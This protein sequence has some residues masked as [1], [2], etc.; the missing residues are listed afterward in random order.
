MQPQILVCTCSANQQCRKLPGCP[1]T[2]NAGCPQWTFQDHISLWF[3]K[4]DE[5]DS[6][7]SEREEI[8]TARNTE[9][10]ARIYHYYLDTY[11]FFHRIPGHPLQ[12]LLEAPLQEKFFCGL[13]TK[14]IVAQ[15][16]IKR[17]IHR[18]RYIWWLTLMH[19]R[20]LPLEEYCLSAG[21]AGAML[22]HR[23]TH[24][25]RHRLRAYGPRA[26]WF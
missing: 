18:L 14:L 23:A 9:A 12:G 3:L 6:R 21:T 11:A 24:D 7:I 2:N 10:I 13:Y 4:R 16:H 5:P 15:A 17:T 8:N 19:S 26:L 1:L 25:L 20:G 22:E